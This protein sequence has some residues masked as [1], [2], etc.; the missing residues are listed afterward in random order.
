MV[1]HGRARSHD[2]HLCAGDTADEVRAF[3]ISLSQRGTQI[4]AA[5]DF[6]EEDHRA[7]ADL[8]FEEYARERR[9][10]R[11]QATAWAATKGGSVQGEHYMEIVEATGHI[12]ETGGTVASLHAL[13]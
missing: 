11:R 1:A 6:E 8:R 9:E 2:A 13:R 7:L 3:R 10:L 12:R 4:F 5:R